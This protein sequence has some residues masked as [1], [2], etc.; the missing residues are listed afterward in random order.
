MKPIEFIQEYYNGNNAYCNSKTQQALEENSA[1]DCVIA[2]H[3][4][5]MSFTFVIRTKRTFMIFFGI[6]PF[7]DFEGVGF[8]LARLQDTYYSSRVDTYLKEFSDKLT[9]LNE[10]EFLNFQ[11][12]RLLKSIKKQ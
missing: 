11:K 7:F 5:D 8:N 12:R 10:T 4:N 6:K 1:K 3:K 2:Y 9:I